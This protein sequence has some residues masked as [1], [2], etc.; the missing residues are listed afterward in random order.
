MGV[1]LSTARYLAPASFAID[2]VAQQYGM[3]S[4]PNMKD[5]HDANLSFFSPQPFFVAG[6]FFPQQ[7]FQVAWLWRLWRA[8]PGDVRLDGDGGDV[9][10]MVDFVPFYAVGNLCIATWMLFWNNSDL[11]TSNIF[12]VINSLTQ[13]YYVFGRRRPLPSSPVMNLDSWD[14]I[15][16]HVVS[17]TFA[18]IGVLDLL[19][20]ASAAYAVGNR[21]APSALVQVLTGV[22]FGA[23]AAASDWVF[24]GCLVYDLVALAVGQRVYGNAQWSNLLGAYAAGTAAI[25]AAKNW[26]RPPYTR[27]IDYEPV[28]DTK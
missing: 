9:A 8:K 11:K 23:L 14:S 2:F 17:T 21:G 10:R 22:G 6:F 1:S 27:T 20:N 5:V 26:A 18:G 19:H 15:L 25:V 3:L 28:R 7:I 13:L 4:R 12:V 16:T 24:G